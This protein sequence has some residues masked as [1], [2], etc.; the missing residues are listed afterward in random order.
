M[1]SLA[2]FYF[3]RGPILKYLANKIVQRAA[4]QGLAVSIHHL[5]TEQFEASITSTSF[6]PYSARLRVDLGFLRNVRW[7]LEIGTNHP[8]KTSLLAAKGEI[9][10]LPPQLTGSYLGSFKGWEYQGEIDFS[11]KEGKW[12]GTSHPQIQSKKWLEIHPDLRVV[13]AEKSSLEIQVRPQ[14]LVSKEIRLEQ[15]LKIVWEKIK[16]DEEWKVTC[17]ALRLNH[18]TSP[19]EG[20]IRELVTTLKRKSANE[21]WAL[22]GEAKPHAQN[23]PFLL[24]YRGNLG[25]QDSFPTDISGR[26]EDP[27]K[28]IPIHFQIQRKAGSTATEA[29]VSG[30]MEIQSDGLLSKILRDLKRE[31]VLSNGTIKLK[32]LLSYS[33][34]KGNF[35][36]LSWDLDKVT[37]LFN[38]VPVRNLSNSGKLRIIPSYQ[39]DR[40]MLLKI[41]RIGSN[42]NIDSFLLKATLNSPDTLTIQEAGGLFAGGSIEVSPFSSSLSEAKGGA[43]IKFKHLELE[44]LLKSLAGQR[45]SGTGLLDG[46][47]RIHW[48]EGGVEIPSLRFVSVGKGKLR[49]TDP[50]GSFFGKKI[51]YLSEFQSLMAEGNQALVMKALENFDYEK[52]EMSATRSITGKLDISLN[53]KGRNPDLIR[54]Q[55]FD[56]TL[57]VSGDVESLLVKSVLQSSVVDEVNKHRN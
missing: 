18:S 57:P 13:L 29:T 49:Y 35:L 4:E 34:E 54:G 28:E 25:L 12:V 33:K 50:M 27:G 11:R 38:Q 21:P 52:L 48:R 36:R 23:Y 40:E 1:V 47:V 30:Q 43:N 56:I 26:L 3:S 37:G 42:L 20:G 46:A 31:V 16:E 22:E 19:L 7:A 9:A 5:S 32:A 55:L 53:L 6:Q 45:L 44:K 24:T 15:P 2:T 51:E 14:D 17:P 41:E 10:I 39:T 8:E